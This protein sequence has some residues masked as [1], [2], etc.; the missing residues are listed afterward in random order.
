MISGLPQSYT[1]VQALHLNTVAPM[2]TFLQP[3]LSS[4]ALHEAVSRLN[5]APMQAINW[6]ILRAYIYSGFCP[7]NSYSHLTTM[8]NAE[9]AV[10]LAEALAESEA[11]SGQ[12]SGSKPPASKHAVRGLTREKLSEQRLKQLGGPDVQCSVCR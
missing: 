6:L 4:N 7:P 10:A 3:L 8:C 1:A 11:M 2:Q 5:K 9:L 12:P